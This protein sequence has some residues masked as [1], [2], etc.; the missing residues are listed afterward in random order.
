MALICISSSLADE[1]EGLLVALH[2]GDKD[3]SGNGGV[4]HTRIKMSV[5]SLTDLT[6]LKAAGDDLL[7]RP[8]D[9]G[10]GANG[11]GSEH[12]VVI[13]GLHRSVDNR[14][15]AC[16]RRVFDVFGI[17]IQDGFSFSGAVG[18]ALMCILRSSS[19]RPMAYSKEATATAS[20]FSKLP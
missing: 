9:H 3:G 17:I 6:L 14:A 13:I 7:K 2:P 19:T 8:L 15:S 10:N 11:P 4:K 1:F 12:R 20:L 5:H 18:A 16:Y